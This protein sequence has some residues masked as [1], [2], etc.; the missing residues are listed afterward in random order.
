MRS[1]DHLITW[2]CSEYG[3]AEVVV[4]HEFCPPEQE[5][6]ITVNCF[7]FAKTLKANPIEVAARV[8]AFFE[9][10][11]DVEKV[12]CVK[13]FVNVTLKAGPLFRDTLADGKGLLEGVA[14]PEGERKRILI[15]Y[16]APNTNKPLHLGHVRNNVLG[17]ATVSL[18]KRIGHDVIPVNLVNDRGIHICKSMIAY[19]RWGE[20]RTPE[21]ENRKGDH[22]VGSLY[23][24]YDVELK[25]QLA[26]LRAGDPALAGESDDALA[27]RTEI[28]AAT[29][30]ML[31]KWEAE[32]PA[33]H[34]L[35]KK[36]NDWAMSG[37]NATYDRMGIVFDKVYFESGTY[38]EGKRIVL[39]GLENGVFS[40]R[41]DGA[42]EADLE[43][44]KLGRK[45]L[46]R[47]DGTS[48][49]ITQ[50][51]GTSVL[52]QN[53]FEP[54]EQIWVVGDEQIHHFKVLFALLKKLGFAWTSDLVHM[55]YGMV[56]LPSGKMKSREGTVVDA[57]ELLDEMERLART[58]C[59]ERALSR[60][61]NP[62]AD[63]DRRAVV[64]GQGALK[65]WLL[66]FKARSRILF[67]PAASIGFE[68]DTG[69]YVQYACARIRSILSKATDGEEGPGESEVEW[70]ALG[71][72]EERG[73]AL[74][75][76][77]YPA[78]V[79]KAA[80]DL[81]PSLLCD[82]LLTL[83]KEFSRFY[84]ACPVLKASSSTLRRER[85]ALCARVLALLEDGLKTLTIDVLESM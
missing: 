24:R 13:A 71:H 9:E 40:K 61:E 72:A 41:E 79:R 47:A 35:W 38:R 44:E 28:G 12:S 31:M 11:D 66:R 59:L 42:I 75:C 73:L 20:G 65:Y 10:H 30:G 22:Y 68:G 76:A 6:D 48:V 16:S 56:D 43:K 57:D 21:D 70:N 5:G 60:G 15:E 34:A 32:D 33:V 78:R 3:I 54:D 4:N 23:V 69:P 37:I 74:R 45:V 84:D 85:L 80:S 49:Y 19:E 64:I 50:D 14:L 83:A 39:G 1:V 18:L 25:E 8:T 26:T 51:I 2:L 7:R 55:S 52:K 82:Y 67:D 36:M 81:D 62:P 63:L 27:D 53:D 29:R 77:A 17:D 46:L 58:G